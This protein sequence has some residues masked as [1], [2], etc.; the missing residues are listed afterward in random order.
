MPLTVLS[1]QPGK[2]AERY[3]IRALHSF[4][5]FG[6]LKA[7]KSA[8]LYLNGGGSLIQ[9]ATSRRSLLYYLFTLWAA[10]RLGCR[11]IMYGCGIGPVTRPGDRHLARR[12]IDRNVDVITLREPGS[13]EELRSW[14]VK[15]PQIIIASD[16][17]MTLPPAGGE[18]VDAFLRSRGMD[19]GGRY[20]GF[21]LRRWPGFQEKAPCF[22]AAARLAYE[23]YGL[24]P[25]FLSINLREDGEAADLAREGLDCPSYGIYDP[26]PAKLAIGILS[27]MTAVVSMRLHGLIFAAGQGVPLVGVSYD[28]KVKEFMEYIGQDLCVAL[29]QLTPELLCTLTEKAI[30]QYPDRAK[31]AEKARLL[32]DLERRSAEAAARLLQ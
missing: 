25:V 23:R 30:A 16:P 3:G 1:R 15:R 13:K 19:P 27:R 31:L 10:K 29:E 9:D 28:P 5:F 26:L 22:T 4:D 18:E 2:T 32:R 24:T 14:G 7:M 8:R 11:V 12:V 21:C 17:A 20:I 6:M